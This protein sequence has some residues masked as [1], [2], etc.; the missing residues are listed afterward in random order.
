V[1]HFLAALRT[2]TAHTGA[3]HHQ[4]VSMRETFTFR[5]AFFAN[6]GADAAYSLMP[7]RTAQHEVGAHI[8]DFRAVH[9]QTDVVGG[10]MLAA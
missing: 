1:G 9:Q 3:T 8:A 2:S 6:I 5:C 10:G 7:V 4:I